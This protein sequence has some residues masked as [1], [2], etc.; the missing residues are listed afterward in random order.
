METQARTAESLSRELA[1]R[2]VMVHGAMAELVRLAAGLV[3]I[4]QE[5]LDGPID[6]LPSARGDGA[7]DARGRSG[8]A[9]PLPILVVPV[10]AASLSGSDPDAVGHL[11]GGPALPHRVVQ[12][13]G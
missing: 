8:A 12:R 10:D 9:R 2:S 6:G 1:D 7:A 3:A 4:C 5:A 13:L 11:E